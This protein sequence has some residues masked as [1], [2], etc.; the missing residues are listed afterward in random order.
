MYLSPATTQK[1]RISRQFLTSKTWQM[2]FGS[3]EGLHEKLILH[4]NGKVYETDNRTEVTSLS[5]WEFNEEEQW[6]Y[7]ELHPDPRTKWNCSLTTVFVNDN[8]DFYPDV[9]LLG[10]Y[11]G[12]VPDSEY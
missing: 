12:I 6:V 9:T 2:H 7:V 1:L 3:K 5:R 11:Y 8:P 10:D 4:P